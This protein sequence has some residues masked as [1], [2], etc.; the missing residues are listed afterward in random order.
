LHLKVKNNALKC[1]ELPLSY[2]VLR[3]IK[4]VRYQYKENTTFLGKDRAQVRSVLCP[5]YFSLPLL[6]LE[7]QV[8]EEVY[9]AHGIKRDI[10]WSKS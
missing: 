9:V 4:G 5:I 3:L 2:N 1:H 7:H 6:I 8:T 10:P